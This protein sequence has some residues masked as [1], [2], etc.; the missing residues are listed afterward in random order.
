MVAGEG[1]G[2]VVFLPGL[3][4]V[5]QDPEVAVGEMAAS[6]GEAIAMLAAFAVVG[7][8]AG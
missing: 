5:V 1:P 2:F 8:G 6:G 4:P 7:P 3:E